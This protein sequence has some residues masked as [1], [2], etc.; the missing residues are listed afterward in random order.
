MCSP[1]PTPRVQEPIAKIHCAAVCGRVAQQDFTFS[2]GITL[3]KGTEVGV[4]IQ[5]LA[6][7]DKHFASAHEFDGL[8]FYNENEDIPANRLS[9]AT[10]DPPM[11][12]WGYG[13]H[14][15]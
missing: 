14:V 13:K 6:M 15:W 1:T 3:P 9:S 11:L 12:G 10:C 7:D 2:N 5:S 4:P 8:R